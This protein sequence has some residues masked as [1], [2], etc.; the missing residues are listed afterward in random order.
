MK[1][2]ASLFIILFISSVFFSGC[3]KI[4]QK[5]VENG[6]EK[7]IENGSGNKADVNISDG[8]VSVKDNAGNGTQIG[9]DI[10]WPEKAP[11]DVPKYSGKITFAT[12]TAD[13]FS[14]V[15]EK[16]D[17]KTF[18]DY[19]DTLVK[20]GFT[21][22]SEMQISDGGYMASFVKDKIQ[23]VITASTSGGVS[24]TINVTKDTN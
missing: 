15:M 19:L 9:G 14:I 10:K 2:L 23:I 4:A 21:R 6:I 3:G 12:S 20:N 22:E 17:K 16:Y 8:S 1:R 7:S 11:Q 5:A 24:I 13:S 18:D